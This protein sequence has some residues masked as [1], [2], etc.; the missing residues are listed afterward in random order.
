MPIEDPTFG[1]GTFLP[2]V[3]PG[4]FSDFDGGGTIDGGGGGDPPDPPD[5][6]DDVGDGVA[7]GGGG[8]GQPPHPGPLI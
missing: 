8:P 1:C 3:G 4:N 7:I 5:P 2:G 6:P